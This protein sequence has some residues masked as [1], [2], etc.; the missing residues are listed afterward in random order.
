MIFP[1][2]PRLPERILNRHKYEFVVGAMRHGGDDLQHPNRVH[3]AYHHHKQ[4]PVKMESLS[5]CTK[6]LGLISRKVLREFL[7]PE[8][9]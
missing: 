1:R 6:N 5:A 8:E 9:I 4:M 2:T 7:Q 3:I